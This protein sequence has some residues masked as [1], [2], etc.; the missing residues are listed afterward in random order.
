MD[1]RRKEHLSEREKALRVKRANKI[2]KVRV[3]AVEF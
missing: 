3:V 2:E 1:E